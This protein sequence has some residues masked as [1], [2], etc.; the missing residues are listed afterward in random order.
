[1]QLLT[2][3][4]AGTVYNVN[5]PGVPPDDALDL[6]WATLDRFGA[7]RL[8]VAGHERGAVQLEL[9]ETGRSSTLTATRRCYA[10]IA[11]AVRM[12]SR[13]EGYRGDRLSINC[14]PNKR[15]HRR[16]RSHDHPQS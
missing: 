1:L 4:P 9:R 10:L 7:V 11:S 14:P 15:E 6:R 8:A 5:G 3:E 12:G 13:T 2:A 16:E